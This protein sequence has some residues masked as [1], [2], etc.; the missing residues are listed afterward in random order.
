MSG[1]SP[2][3]TIAT[4]QRGLAGRYRVERE[5]GA[6]GMAIVYLARDLQHERD[7][8]L[9]VLRFDVGDATMADRFDREIR[10]A[11][12]LVHPHILPLLDSGA[13]EGHL[14]YAM[15]F[16]SGE[17]L[18][19]LLARE[20][21][22]P[23][24]DAIRLAN[25]VAD[26]L[27]YA[28]EQG[29]LHRDIKP[30]NI[31]LA[32]GHA[33]VTDFGIARAL[34][35]SAES[36]TRTGV[37]LGTPAYMSPE[38]STGEQQLGPRTD[39][40]ALATVTY[41]MLAGEP[42][43]TGPTAQVVIAR[44]LSQPPPSIRMVRP[45]IPESVDA[46][47]QRGLA[48]TPADRF[49]SAREFGR[50][51]AE[52]QTAEGRSSRRRS[53]VTATAGIGAIIL[54]VGLV[55]W[56]VNLGAPQAPPASPVLADRATRLA[57]LPFRLIGADNS[58]QYLADGITQEIN[59][60]LANLSGLRVLD[61][62]SVEA[63]GTGKGA[64]EIGALLEV[65]ALV[66]GDVQK[67]GDAIRVRV[68]LI[69][70][71][72]QAS[73]WSE[74][75]DHTASDIFK[76]QSEV[77]SKVAGVLRIQVAERES[78]SLSRPPTTIPQA[79]DAYLRARARAG[80][81]A[82]DVRRA[83]VD[84]MISDLR[85]AIAIDST[86]ATAW[87]HFALNLV[88]SVF[89]FNADIARLD[90]ADR[91]IATAL[92]FDS[93]LAIA[94]K[95]RHDLVW[96]AE[97]GWHFPQALAD[98]RRAITL[99]PSLREA[100]NALGALYFHYG[101]MKEARDEL[102]LSLSLD[103]QDGCRDLRRCAGFSRPR[104]ARVLWYEQKFDSAL[105]VY[106]KLPFVGGFI[107]EEAVVLN[108]M[109]RPAEA[110]TLLDSA[111]AKG[112]EETEDRQAARALAHAS[113][114]HTAQAL[115]HVDSALARRRSR[116][117]FHHAQFTIACAYARLGRTADAVEWLRRTAAD[118]MPNYPLFQ[119]DPNLRSLHGDRGYEALM[120]DLRRQF[121]SFGELVRSGTQ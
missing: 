42:P 50:A 86:F 111:R 115:A 87:G 92:R 23:L 54:T 72:S 40:Y 114:G 17:S 94:W 21:Q 15:P 113:L 121:E 69:D 1:G 46:V 38:Q 12:R 117:H 120:T 60:A 14:W 79:Y 10:L 2:D 84:S 57:V 73:I 104:I 116:S 90:E 78:R 34:T 59:S 11:A 105:A 20:K 103:P 81:S 6:G 85:S 62:N 22:L 37:A 102:A 27:Q 76:V 52:A 29:V 25:E 7:V 71:P 91:A 32:S 33:L 30:D 109:G 41:E 45:T 5:I 39:I 9:K 100:H 47:L 119:N 74:T 65:D 83:T 82:P 68:K 63:V 108:A 80:P 8:A 66:D 61:G 118:G 19:S 110:L 58:A 93:T 16:V 55:A 26:A 112:D 75:Y 44:R 95:A 97:R 70:P 43:F 67:A 53:S 77:A 107:W 88:R 56:L 35:E 13:V 31:L 89:L 51:L 36:I 96:T 48:L 24:N 49:S 99:Q 64:R 98:V 106:R 28:H 3:V 18:R 4:L 101:F